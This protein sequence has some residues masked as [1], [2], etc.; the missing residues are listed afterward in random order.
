MKT[1]KDIFQ[2]INEL[3]KALTNEELKTLYWLTYEN[4]EGILEA[5]ICQEYKSRGDF[6]NYS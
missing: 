4:E 5:Y 6:D 3:I 2:S 1:S